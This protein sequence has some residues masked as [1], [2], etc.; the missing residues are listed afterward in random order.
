MA[1]WKSYKMAVP[2]YG[3]IML[4][5]QLTKVRP[6]DNSAHLKE[7]VPRFVHYHFIIRLRDIY[8]LFD[9]CSA[10]RLNLFATD[11]GAFGIWV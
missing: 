10:A 3:A 4:N 7:N 11:H 6:R 8:K 2:T 9:L 1:D 5:E